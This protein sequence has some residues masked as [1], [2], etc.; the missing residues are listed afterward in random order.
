M[1]TFPTIIISG[2]DQQIHLSANIS[3]YSCI[4]TVRN[5][6]L[7]LFVTGQLALYDK[8]EALQLRL[9]FTEHFMNIYRSSIRWTVSKVYNRWFYHSV[10]CRCIL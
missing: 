9:L 5:I 7:S 1:T 10:I 6:Y 8:F 2:N 4:N 3:S